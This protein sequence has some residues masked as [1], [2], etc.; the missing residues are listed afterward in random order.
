MQ[1]MAD[2]GFEFNLDKLI[3]AIALFANQGIRDLTKLK[4]AKL[5]YFADK[6]H[7]LEYGQPIIGDVYWCMEFGPVPSFA[8]NEMSE[9]I[10]S[11]EIES[12]AISDSSRMHEVLK[13]RKPLFGRYPCFEA[14]RPF[15]PA[16]FIGSEIKVLH[17]VSARYGSETARQL[18]DL[19]HKEPTWLIANETR[20]LQ[21]RAPIPYDL[22]FEGCTAESLK[23]LARLKADN[24]GEV[25]ALGGDA[26]FSEFASGLRS[27][28]FEPEFDLDSDCVR[29]RTASSSH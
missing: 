21:S 13:V 4:V 14:K 9:A 19:T 17:D 12:S 29:E 2:F 26:E 18:V 5:L 20:G 22:F 23:H 8:M 1:P 25:I 15:D 10:Q 24:C 6:Q 3:H 7:L 11:S 16:V 28:A 27:Y